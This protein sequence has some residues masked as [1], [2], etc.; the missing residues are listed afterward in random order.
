MIPQEKSAAV[1]RAMQEAFG[2]TTIEEIRR[3]TKGLSSDLVLRIVV[4]GSPYLLR[5]MM[6]MDEQMNPGRIFPCMNAASD[7]GLTPRVRYTNAEDGISITDFVED[8]PLPSTQALDLL[9][10]TL[11]ALHTL[12]PFPKEFNYVTAHN[13]FIWKFR[14][15]SLLPQDEIDEAFFHY[16][17][18]CAAYPRLEADMVSC[19]MDL[20]P[21]N[22]L[23]D[24]HRIWLVDWQAA[25]LNDRYFDLAVAA[26]CLVT[27]EADEATYLGHYFAQP[28]D[29][30]QR[31]RFFLMCQAL[32]MLS[33]AVFLLLGSGGKPIGE[34]YDLPSFEDFHRRVW[35]GQV[36][37]ADKNQQIL[38]GMV[39][40]KRLQHSICQP[41]FSESL[42]IIAQRHPEGTPHLFPP[43]P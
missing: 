33:A 13:Y 15:A 24:G 43:G 4:N 21:D 6:R 37:L 20:K 26:N 17:H 3:M 40:W 5:I 39:P 10:L 19:H 42:R 27:S 8:L 11:R 16:E 29:E 31:A 2:T 1:S 32:H 18:L 7:A 14:N 36:N 41:R 28:P 22:I 12:P 38:S 34:I 25:F 35:T 23:Y 30:Y 9:P